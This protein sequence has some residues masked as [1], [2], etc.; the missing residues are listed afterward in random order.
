VVFPVTT[1][2][3]ANLENERLRGFEA[4]L[5]VTLSRDA[6]FNLTL[7]DNKVKNAVANV[8]LAANTRERQNLDAIHARGV[9]LGAQFG[10]GP[11]RFFGTLAYTDAEVEASEGVQADLDGNRPAQTPKFAAS[12]TVSYEP[13][14]DWRFAA[15]LR[16]VGAQFEGDQED[17][18]LPAA[19]TVDLFGQVPVVARLSVIARVE[20]LF[21]E[22]IVTRNQG[23]SI[24]L[25][26]P[27]TFWAGLRWGY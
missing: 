5:D 2:A 12:A 23:G 6:E 26:A 3:N 13:R 9:E 7:F 27:Q 10:S 18:V 14:D 16:H 25:G 8:T 24:D 20:N 4:G 15:T 19:T 11:L 21:D 22:E 1:N 17:D